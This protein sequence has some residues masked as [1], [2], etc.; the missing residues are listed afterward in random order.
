MGVAN[1][2]IAE[3]E[4]ELRRVEDPH[5]QP[6]DPSLRHHYS[7]AEERQAA[8]AFAAE[9]EKRAQEKEAARIRGK[10]TW[11]ILRRGLRKK[12]FGVVLSEHDFRYLLDEI[13]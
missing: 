11:G 7:L 4:A 1:R 12:P 5:W 9:E 2:V 13:C 6:A 8:H 10:I 3:I